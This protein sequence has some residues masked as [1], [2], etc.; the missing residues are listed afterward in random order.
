MDILTTGTVTGIQITTGTTGMLVVLVGVLDQ[1][2]QQVEWFILWD[3]PVSQ[4]DAPPLWVVRGINLSVLREALVSQQT[5]SISH[6]S[7]SGIVDMVVFG[8]L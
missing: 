2:T 3:V 6:D 5:V 7:T 1:S 4:F 8:N